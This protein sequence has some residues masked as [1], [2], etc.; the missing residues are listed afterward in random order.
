MQR[1]HACCLFLLVLLFLGDAKAQ[2][3]STKYVPSSTQ[4]L[5]AYCTDSNNALIPSCELNL[6]TGVYLNTNG[7]FHNIGRP[8]SSVYPS[9]GVTS[10]VAPYG[11]AITISTTHVGQAE[12]A[13][14]QPVWPGALIGTHEYVVGYS[15]IFWNHHDDIWVQVGGHTTGHGSNEYNHWMAWDAAHG[16]YHATRDYLLI[17]RP[18]RARVA[19]NDMALPFGGK[20]DIHQDWT[21]AH[22]NHQRGTSVDIRGNTSA[23]TVPVSDQVLFR[24]LC[25]LHNASDGLSHIEFATSGDSDSYVANPNRH[26]HCQWPNP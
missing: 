4:N 23:N 6:Y 9:N 8:I 14:A 26:I 15:D 25:V 2:S 20:F 10:G 21:T 7:H 12:L 3:Y 5:W 22:F 11:L 18:G 16:I 24:N 13:L 19:V 17:H 1:F